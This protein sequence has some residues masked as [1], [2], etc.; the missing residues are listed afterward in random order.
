MKEPYQDI[1]ARTVDQWVE[2]GWEWGTPVTHEQFLAAQAG[3]WSIV[4]TPTKPVPRDWFPNLKG[5]K[6]LVLHAV[7]ASRCRCLRQRAV[8]TVLDYSERQLGER[9]DGSRA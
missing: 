2:D 4:L 3:N 8:C 6:L 5:K 7:A 1:N 9:A